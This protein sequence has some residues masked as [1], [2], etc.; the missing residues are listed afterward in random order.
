MCYSSIMTNQTVIL[1]CC[2]SSS[3]AR[4]KD[5]GWTKRLLEWQPRIG[6]RRRGRQKRRWRDGITSYIGITWARVAGDKK[7]W[8]D[9][10]EGYIQQWMD[11]A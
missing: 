7:V 9:Y 8:N 1:D 5:N 4:R 2:T 3:V 11:K 10:E 6:K